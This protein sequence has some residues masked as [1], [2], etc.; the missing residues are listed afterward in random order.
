MVFSSITFIFFFLP[1]VLAAYHLAPRR[2][3]NGLL[4]FASLGFYAWGAGA[5][6]LAGVITLLT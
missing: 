3:R 1:A 6:V 2:V 5:F 4:V